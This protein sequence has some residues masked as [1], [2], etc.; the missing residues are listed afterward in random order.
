M[1]DPTDFTV[2]VVDLQFPNHLKGRMGNR[3]TKEYEREK[4]VGNIQR[5]YPGFN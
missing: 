3:T 2:I 5:R 1:R 4:N